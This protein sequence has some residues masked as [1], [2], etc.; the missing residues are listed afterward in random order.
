M[1][2]ICGRSHH[3]AGMPHNQNRVSLSRVDYPAKGGKHG[4]GKEKALV[5]AT[6]SGDSGGSDLV[7]RLAIYDRLLQS[8]LVAGLAW[9]R[10]LA[11]LSGPVAG[12]LREHIPIS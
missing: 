1:S 12:W 4:R 9:H 7:H 10:N 3:S 2:V 5:P 11:V 8:S 6:W